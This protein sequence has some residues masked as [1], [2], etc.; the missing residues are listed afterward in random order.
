MQAVLRADMERFAGFALLDDALRA[1]PLAGAAPDARV[2]DAI[3]T[4]R[5]CLA[6]QAVRLAEDRMDAQVEVDTSRISKI[7]LISRV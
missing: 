2:G 3:P 7:T 5:R 1:H 6:V 4:H